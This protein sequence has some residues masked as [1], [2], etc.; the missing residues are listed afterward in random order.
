VKEYLSVTVPVTNVL[1][2]DV[3]GTRIFQCHLVPQNRSWLRTLRFPFP[4]LF[5]TSSTVKFQNTVTGLWL[6]ILYRRLA[7]HWCQ[8][9]VFVI[10]LPVEAAPKHRLHV[11]KRSS[12]PSAHI[13]HEGSRF[14]WPGHT[15]QTS[16]ELTS[17]KLTAHMQVN[18]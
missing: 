12:P 16:H 14:L 10:N 18:T 17:L 4:S 7:S 9:W 2:A 15:I 3:L 8:G 13:K 11:L 6:F 5:P 1:L